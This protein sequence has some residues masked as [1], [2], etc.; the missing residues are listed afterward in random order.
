[1]VPPNEFM[2]QLQPPIAE[3]LGVLLVERGVSFPDGGEELQSGL[4]ADSFSSEENGRE[5]ELRSITLRRGQPQFR[6]ALLA[7]YEHRCA[8]T[9]CNAREVLEA[10]HIVPYNGHGTNHVRN[11]LL[12][13]ADIHTLFD[14]GVLR[15]HPD[16]LTVELDPSLARTDYWKLNGVRLRLPQTPGH[17]PSRA[18]LNERLSA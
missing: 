14:L 18:A 16:S 2:P 7:A 4:L 9:G 12:L 10:A 17:R 6:K 3:R 8:V 13:R 1:M 15:I 11:G 5:R